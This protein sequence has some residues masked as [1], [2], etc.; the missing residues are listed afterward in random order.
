MFSICQTFLDLAKACNTVDHKMLLHNIIKY[1]IG[2]KAIFWFNNYPS[3][4][5]ESV[6]LMGTN[7]IKNIVTHGVPQG[8]ILGTL[9][10]IMYINDTGQYMNKCCVNLC[11]DDTALD[12]PAT[13]EVELNKNLTVRMELSPVPEWLKANELTLTIA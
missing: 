6:K 4:M 13:P 1:N 8:S 2:P 7:S 10:F 12:V 11:A 3:D 9:L 5:P